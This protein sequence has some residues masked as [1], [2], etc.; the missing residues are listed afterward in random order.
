MG[1]AGS[2]AVLHALHSANIEVDRVHAHN[3]KDINPD[4]YRY[5]VAMVR[6][7]IARSI[8]NYFETGKAVDIYSEIAFTVG[9]VSNYVLPIT[10]MDILNAGYRFNT[11][12]GWT[13][14]SGDDRENKKRLLVI[15]TESFDGELSLA[16]SVLLGENKKFD[17]IHHPKGDERF[18]PEYQEFKDNLKLDAEFV[19]GIEQSPYCQ[20]FGYDDLMERYRDNMQ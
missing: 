4:Q 18:G 16:L 17:V 12:F 14:Y 1:K 7:P 20:L 9:F 13:V 5:F 11:A 6:E 2:T 10:G 8:S 19:K 15:R 3:L